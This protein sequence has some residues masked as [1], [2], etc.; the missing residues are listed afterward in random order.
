VALVTDFHRPLHAVT[1][2]AGWKPDERPE[3]GRHGNGEEPGVLV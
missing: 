1:V 3:T 2:W